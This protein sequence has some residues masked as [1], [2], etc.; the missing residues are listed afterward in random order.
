MRPILIG[1]DAGNIERI[2]QKMLVSTMGN[3]MT[4]T[5]GSGAMNA[6]DMALWDIKGQGAQ[7]A[8]LEPARWQGARPYS[9]LRSRF[10]SRTRP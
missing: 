2:W 7:Y 8:G 3:G 9:R 4:G 10:D 6:I 5:P 1:E